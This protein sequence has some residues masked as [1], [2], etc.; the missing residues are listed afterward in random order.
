VNT[1]AQGVELCGCEC[2]AQRIPNKTNTMELM[3][4]YNHSMLKFMIN[5]NYCKCTMLVA[6]NLLDASKC[7]MQGVKPDHRAA[8]QENKRQNG[9]AKMHVETHASKTHICSMEH[10]HTQ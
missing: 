1:H 6:I 4:S 7:T 10:K 9:H 8:P 5:S 3:Q 2:H